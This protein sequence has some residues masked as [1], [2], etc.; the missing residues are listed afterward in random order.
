MSAPSSFFLSVSYP[1]SV[2]RLLGMTDIATDALWRLLEPDDG[3]YDWD[4]WQRL[5]E[6]KAAQLNAVREDE[7]GGRMSLCLW[8]VRRG[9]PAERV[10]WMIGHTDAELHAVEEKVK[11]TVLHWASVSE[12]LADA[13]AVAVLDVLHRRVHPPLDPTAANTIGNLPIHY[14]AWKDKVSVVRYFVEEWG[15]DADVRGW[16]GWTPLH[17]A[18]RH[19]SPATV[20]YLTVNA[21]ADVG[22][23]NWV[24][25]CV[26]CSTECMSGHGPLLC[27]VCGRSATHQLTLPMEA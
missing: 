12:G 14:A 15:V 17:N 6:V 1:I 19:N 26:E 13:E 3:P 22:A 9:L 27:G 8:S 7:H 18:A 2:L 24:C 11:Y 23:K 25:G 21:G 5:V 16:N 10:Q 4:E 20:A